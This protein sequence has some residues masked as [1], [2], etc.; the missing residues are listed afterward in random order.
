MLKFIYNKPALLY[1]DCLIVADV[2]LGVEQELIEKGIRV[3]SITNKIK[4]ELISIL[5]ETK[6]KKLIFAGDLK[7]NIPV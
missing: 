2:H 4:N 6:A 1:K 7:H 5:E 3:H